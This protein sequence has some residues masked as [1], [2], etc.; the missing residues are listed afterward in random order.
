VRD[1]SVRYLPTAS[2]MNRIAVRAESETLLALAGRL[3][4]LERPVAAR[5]VVL[6][7]RLLL[8]PSGP[9]YDRELADDLPAYLDCA[10]EALEPR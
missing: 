10:L 9:L 8:E 3:A 2:P 6:L 7:E 1:A 5:S 4:D